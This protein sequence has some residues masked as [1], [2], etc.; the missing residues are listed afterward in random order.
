ME[1]SIAHITHQIPGHFLE[2]VYGS[3]DQEFHC[4]GCKIPGYGPRYRCH[5]CDFN[6]HMV[7]G[8]CPSTLSTFIHLQHI[9]RLMTSDCKRVCHLCGDDVE[10]LFYRCTLC[11]FNIHPLCTKLRQEIFLQSLHP[12]CPLKLQTTSSAGSCRL[13][14]TECTTSSWV[15]GCR[16]CGFDIHLRCILAP[17]HKP[18][19]SSSRSLEAPPPWGVYGGGNGIPPY[20]GYVPSYTHHYS[21][22]PPPMYNYWLPYTH[23][24]SSI[25]LPP[26]MHN[27]WPSFTSSSAYSNY[28]YPPS[29]PPP[30]TGFSS[31]GFSNQGQGG[32]Q[33]QPSKWKLSR[34]I[35]ALAGNLSMGVLCNVIASGITA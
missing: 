1:P 23:Y 31:H 14:N 32:G 3:A 20:N 6:M 21:F 25:P 4:D 11:D 2:E 9:L 22:T 15:Y 29:H 35:A 33:V 13:C 28:V 5:D 17:A 8:V 27:Y 10:G 16:I 7:C 26:S 24:S 12:T 30:T 18:A 34:I 19:T